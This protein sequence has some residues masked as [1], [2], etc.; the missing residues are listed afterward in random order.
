MSLQ[1]PLAG[2]Y[3]AQ[4]AGR[5]PKKKVTELSP[6]NGPV[7]WIVANLLKKEQ[8]VVGP[9]DAAFLARAHVAVEHGIEPSILRVFFAPPAEPPGS[10]PDQTCTG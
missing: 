3:V 6:P 1:N 4:T 5:T 7:L 10:K 9:F 8:W 2:V